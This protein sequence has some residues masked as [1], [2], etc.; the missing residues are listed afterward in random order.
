[1]ANHLKSMT[2]FDLQMKC[3]NRISKVVLESSESSLVST[4]HHFLFHH[5]QNAGLLW[6][7]EIP[8]LPKESKFMAGRF[9]ALIVVVAPTM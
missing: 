4:P 5:L 2:K 7:I 9:T 6:H 1:M 3:K 8:E